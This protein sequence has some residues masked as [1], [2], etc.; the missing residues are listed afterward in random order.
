MTVFTPPFCNYELNNLNFHYIPFPQKN[1]IQTF[2]RRLD[3]KKRTELYFSCVCRLVILLSPRTLT[4]SKGALL[5]WSSSV[6]CAYRSR[7]L[8]SCL[9][10]SSRAPDPWVSLQ[11]RSRLRQAHPCVVSSTLTRR[12]PPSYLD[13]YRSFRSRTVVS[14]GTPVNGPYWSIFHFSGNLFLNFVI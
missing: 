6:L 10:F 13:P 8:L 12:R 1:R 7:N 11:V 3:L 5:R 4:R 2:I 9:N 14:P